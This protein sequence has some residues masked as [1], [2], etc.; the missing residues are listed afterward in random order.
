[1]SPTV[2]KILSY[3]LVIGYVIT[4]IEIYS[5]LQFW[6]AALLDFFLMIFVVVG[7]GMLHRKEA[8]ESGAWE[9]IKQSHGFWD[10]K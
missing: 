3:T 1:M 6:V 10:K 4:A 9:Y 7:I 8:E 2:K 5:F